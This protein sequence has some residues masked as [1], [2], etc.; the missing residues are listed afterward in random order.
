[1]ILRQWFQDVGIGNYWNSKHSLITINGLTTP[2]DLMQMKIR[3][4]N[5]VR[6]LIKSFGHSYDYFDYFST[7]PTH[8]WNR[9]DR[10]RPLHE[11]TPRM[12]TWVTRHPEGVKLQNTKGTGGQG[13]R[14]E[15]PK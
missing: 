13:K 5:R 6:H 9:R 1:M 2:N 7:S 14:T 3:Q 12:W 8:P 11:S 15:C 10:L 4:T